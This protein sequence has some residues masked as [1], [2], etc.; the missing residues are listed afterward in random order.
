MGTVD[1][2]VSELHG[3]VE[4]I[5]IIK[6]IYSIMEKHRKFEVLFSNEQAG[7]EERIVGEFTEEEHEVL[8]DFMRFSEELYNGPFLRSRNFGS[9]KIGHT[10][11]EA[12]TVEVDLPNWDE[13]MVFL[14]RLRPLILESERTSFYKVRTLIGYRARH[15]Q[16]Q[17]ML[18]SQKDIYS[19][20]RDQR[21]IQIRS[22]DEL[23]NSEKVLQSYLNGFEY[24]RD[25]GKQKFIENLHQMLPL[26]FSKVIFVGLLIEKAKAIFSLANLVAVITGKTKEAMVQYY[27][28]DK[29][30]GHPS[31]NG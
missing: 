4:W 15:P 31:R 23:V 5:E 24:H 17:M 14:H 27:K 2:I 21:I 20:K 28:I 7:A 11:G 8:V 16:V 10:A 18:D 6:I 12:L 1:C 26:D 3:E 19:G 22:N 25:K 30:H 29:A 13:V 9:A